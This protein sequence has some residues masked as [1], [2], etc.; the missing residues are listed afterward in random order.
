MGLLGG[1]SI[2]R[3]WLGGALSVLPLPK[4]LR[5]RKIHNPYLF[6]PSAPQRGAVGLNPVF[7]FIPPVEE[8]YE[9]I[10]TRVRAAVVGWPLRQSEQDLAE[11]AR[12]E[13]QG[14][15]TSKAMG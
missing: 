5:Y 4:H 6:R 1:Y 14:V 13:K 15:I 11:G 10:K 12:G 8:T 7:K 9:K 2:C 3:T